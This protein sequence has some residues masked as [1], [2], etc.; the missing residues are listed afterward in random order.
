MEIAQEVEHEKSMKKVVEKKEMKDF[1]YNSGLFS[2]LRNNSNITFSLTI[3]G[4]HTAPILENI[5][6]PP[7]A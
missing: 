6:P 3:I 7:N 1:I 5:V 4:N 2:G